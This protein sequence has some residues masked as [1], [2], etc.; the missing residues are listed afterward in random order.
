MTSRQSVRGP[1][2]GRTLLCKPRR[3]LGLFVFLF[4]EGPVCPKVTDCLAPVY[5]NVETPP[6]SKSAGGA[7]LGLPLSPFFMVTTT[8]L[9]LRSGALGKSIGIPSD[10][11]R[12]APPL[13]YSAVV[14]NRRT[15][16]RGLIS[17]GIGGTLRGGH[18]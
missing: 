11:G 10:G 18:R 16:R 12:I 17:P 1:L 5:R 14:Q 2:S 6:F 9:T 7:V 8:P 13:W 4:I 15:D 3:T